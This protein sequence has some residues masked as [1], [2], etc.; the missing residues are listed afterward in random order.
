VAR[1]TRFLLILVLGLG[2]KAET[3]GVEV[4]RGGLE[5]LSVEDLHR[6]TWM[7][8]NGLDDRGHGGDDEE[9]AAERLKKRL[10]EM[11]VLPGYARAYKSRNGSGPWRTCGL[12]VGKRRSAHIWMA[13][14]SGKG[15]VGGAIP[16]AILI[17]LAKAWDTYEQLPQAQLFCGL[18][19]D[20]LDDYIASPAY[21]L[22]HTRIITSFGPLGSGNLVSTEF[23]H[24]GIRRVHFSTDDAILGTDEDRM[25]AVDYRVVLTHLETIFATTETDEVE[26]L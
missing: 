17:S 1:R 25:E 10:Q 7:F 22:E 11:R 13:L 21:P 16:R 4:H 18:D 12:K 24:Q 9:Q 2:C 15:A 8:T 5:S 20:G 6:D 26:D 19:A 3:L 14:D 23:D